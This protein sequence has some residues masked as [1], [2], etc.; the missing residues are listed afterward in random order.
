M[1]TRDKNKD[2]DLVS[3]LNK[4]LNWNKARVKLLALL[5]NAMLKLQTVSFV[6]LSQ[7]IESDAK[8]S[9]N[10]RRIQRFFAD[11]IFSED[12]I[13]KLLYAMLPNKSSNM[14]CLDRTNWKHGKLNINILMLSV[15]YKGVSIPLMWKMLPKRGNSNSTE[16]KELFDRY[17]RLFGVDSI[18]S[19]LA[20][21]EFIGESWF[22]LL[23]Q[24]KVRFYIRIKENMLVDVAGKGSKKAFW[25]FN[26]LAL[27]VPR[28]YDKPMLFRGRYL[29]LS[30]IKTVGKSNQI[31][32]VIIAT[33]SK[34]YDALNTYKNR[35]Q[36]ETMFK[37]F[38]T[39]GFNLE[40]SHLKD[41]KRFSK[42]LAVVCI[43][44]TWAYKIGIF[45]DHNIKSIE[46][47]KHGRKAMSY[48][49]YGLNFIAH[50][51]LNRNTIDYK[52]CVKILS[53]T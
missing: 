9:S 7:G 36:I 23:I 19:L 28:Y 18:D 12:T 11:F 47:K 34:D 52:Q 6:K 24:H 10:L 37:A 21:R 32:F 50:A 46:I 16:R 27:N 44:F 14:L 17:I 25:L 13:A 2:N 4:N 33:F 30:G 39:S 48:F 42:L 51:L 49:K 15:A 31:E 22:D 41:I 20:D 38:K 35:W 43:A 29:Y 26:D 53:C 3:T 40:Q 5:I 1:N 8:A 45:L